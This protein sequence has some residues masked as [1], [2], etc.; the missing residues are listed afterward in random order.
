MNADGFAEGL[1]AVL[2]RS[3][4]LRH[5]GSSLSFD[6]SDEDIKTIIRLRPGRDTL[7]ELQQDQSK[8]DVFLSSKGN[9]TRHNDRIISCSLLKWRADNLCKQ[10]KF[11]EA[12]IEYD[13]ATKAVLGRDF[14]F[15]LPV[16][17][18]FRNEV[19]TKLSQWERIV[20]MECCNGMAQCMIKLKCPERVRRPLSSH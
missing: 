10:G 13:K 17:E 16:T 8:A 6:I 4:P 18:G 1:S 7:K 20:L 14:V 3:V 2:G 5:G 15:P 9:S 12:K 11:E 19:Y